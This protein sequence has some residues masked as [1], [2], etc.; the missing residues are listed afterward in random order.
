MTEEEFKK[1]EVQVNR[2]VQLLER[3]RNTSQNVNVQLELNMSNMQDYI[4]YLENIV[5]E[6]GLEDQLQQAPTPEEIPEE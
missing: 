1:F 2:T 5:K 6:N 3:Q 4:T